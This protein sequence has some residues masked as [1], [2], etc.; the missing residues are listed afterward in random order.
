MHA[1]AVLHCR[2]APSG[3][4]AR[5]SASLL[6]SLSWQIVRASSA[7]RKECSEH[8]PHHNAGGVAWKCAQAQGLMPNEV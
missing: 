4:R 8:H 6:Q 7:P 1:M 2:P 5:T 3:W